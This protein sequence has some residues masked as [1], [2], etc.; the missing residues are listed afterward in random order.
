MPRTPNRSILHPLEDRS[1]YCN[2]CFLKQIQ[3]ICFLY[4]LNLVYYTILFLSEFPHHK[5]WNTLHTG[6]NRSILHPLE[7]RSV[8][9]NPCFLKQ[10]Q[11][12]CFLYSLN[13]D[14]YTI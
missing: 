14:Y 8:Y 5:S 10:I 11:G 2:P 13:L 12:I 4:S 6:T 9:C 7:D 1:V 3:G